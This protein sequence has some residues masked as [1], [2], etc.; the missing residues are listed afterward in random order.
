MN[1]ISQEC[2]FLLLLFIMSTN[3]LGQKKFAVK[4]Q[5]P[6]TLESKMFSINYDNGEKN[7][8]VTDSFRNNKL[9]LT[10]TF[11][12]NFATLNIKYKV[13]D[14]VSYSSSYF[15]DSKPA[16]I[17]FMVNSN[18]SEN[19]FKNCIVKNAFD[20]YQSDIAKRRVEFNKNEL[21]EM[22]NFWKMNAPLI[23]RVDSITAVFY[24]KLDHITEKDIQF[25][26]NNRNEYFSFWWFK[27]QVVPNTLTTAHGDLTKIKTLLSILVTTFPKEFTNSIEG[28]N[29]KTILHGRL[30]TRKNGLAPDFKAKDITG[31]EVILKDLRGHY[32]LLDF[33]ATWCPPCI[34]QIPFLKKLREEYSED[35]LTIISISADFDYTRFDSVVKDKM[36]NWIHIY[37]SKNLPQTFGISA[38]P[39]LF[40]INDQGV[41]IYDGKQQ[42][43]EDL[44]QL[45]KLKLTI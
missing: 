33:W 3:L 5:L 29:L 26:K 44:L 21:A 45:I 17:T 23:G 34:K 27:T 6:L 31:K 38:Y 15:I 28:R 32:V 7:Q 18:K 42:K 24:N 14:S 43:K 10:G 25:I 9:Q 2:F 12:S 20:I 22:N 35:K 16:E 30:N 13:N 39:T 1:R 40:L 19:P 4:I 11:I 36:M 8:P 41:I 37:D